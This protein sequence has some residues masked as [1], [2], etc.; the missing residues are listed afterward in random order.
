MEAWAILKVLRLAFF[1]QDANV[2]AFL[3]SASEGV[4]TREH[5]VR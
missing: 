2:A 3:T 5:H 4:S 1:L